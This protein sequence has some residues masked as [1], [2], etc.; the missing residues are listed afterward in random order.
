[1]LREQSPPGSDL[2]G[3][4]ALSHPA[5]APPCSGTSRPVPPCLSASPIQ[6][7]QI[8][9]PCAQWSPRWPCLHPTKPTHWHPVSRLLFTSM[10]MVVFTFAKMASPSHHLGTLIGSSQSLV[11]PLAA[12]ARDSPGEKMDHMTGKQRARQVRDTL[13]D[14]RS[15]RRAA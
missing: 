13:V 12:R 6:V 4:V 9:P 8:T 11:T 7:G 15:L 3:S 2:P 5:S 1:M 14:P 10:E